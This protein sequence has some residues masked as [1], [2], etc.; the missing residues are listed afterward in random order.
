MEKLI[1]LVSEKTGIS[2]TQAK[3]AVDTVI[4]FLKDKMPAGIGNQVESF[5]KGSGISGMGEGIKKGIGDIFGK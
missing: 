5:V 2:D 1:K 3:A 4:G